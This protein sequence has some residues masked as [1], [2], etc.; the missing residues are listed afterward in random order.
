M[1]QKIGLGLALMAALIAGTWVAARAA[2]FVTSS[3]RL[4]MRE[5][6]VV[7]SSATYANGECYFGYEV[8]QSTQPPFELAASKPLVIGSTITVRGYYTTGC[9]PGDPGYNYAVKIQRPQ[10]R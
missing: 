7:L 4:Q 6:L 1:E 3:Q 8:Q 2:G 5:D 9:G 10:S